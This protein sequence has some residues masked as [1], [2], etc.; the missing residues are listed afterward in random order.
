MKLRSRVVEA[1]ILDPGAGFRPART[2][3]E[4]RWDPLTG[5]SSRILP[6]RGLMPPGE[7]DLEA[8][9]EESRAT[10]PFCPDRIES[11]TPKLTPAVAPEGRIRVGRAVLFPNLLPYGA[12]SSVSVYAPDL[13]LLRLGDMTPDLVADNLAAQVAWVRAVQATDPDARWAS[14]SA[15]HFVPSGSSLFHP[16]LQGL[17]DREP[18]TVQ[19]VLSE[20]P[21]GRFAEYLDTE[22]DLGA[23][24]VGRIG[25]VEWL[26]GFAPVGPAEIRAFV[27]GAASP[28]EL[29][30]RDVRDLGRGI[31]TVLNLYADLGYES[32]NLAACGVPDRP[33]DVRI[34]ARSSLRPFYRSDV[35]SLERLH[36]E[37]A[38]DVSPE[39]LAL[40]AGER[41]PTP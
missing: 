14:V 11:R 24:Y 9:A 17:V 35:T 27:P 3:V 33:L 26:A 23:R 20:V 21:A 25:R 41:F 36:F 12:H 5:H 40:R 1:E 39:D 34:V 6:A 7:A 15:N 38:V 22:R 28:A 13:H 8:L 16:H 31:A 32:F 18:T 30:E 2:V 37:G 10:C 19:R 29:D 4:I